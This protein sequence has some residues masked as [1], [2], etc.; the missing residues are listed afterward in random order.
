MRTRHGVLRVLLA[1]RSCATARPTRLCAGSTPEHSDH[2][3]AD[4]VLEH[5][6]ADPASLELLTGSRL[7][8]YGP[9]APAR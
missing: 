3:R 2:R 8:L 7:A 5:L 1:G 6:G 9:A 4:T